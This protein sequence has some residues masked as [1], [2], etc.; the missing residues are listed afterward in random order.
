MTVSTSINSVV[1]RGNGA[2]TQ[3]AV[4]F[5]VLDVDHLRVKRRVFAT[6]ALDYT[7]IGTDYSYSGIDADSGTLT[8]SGLA[9]DDDYE[10]VIERIVPYTQDLDIV[11]AGGFYPETVE[12]QLD[13]IVMGVQQLADLAGRAVTVPVG[14]TVSELLNADERAGRFL[15]FDVNGDVI[16]ST[17]TGADAGLRTD[18]AA[19]TGATL[20]GLADG[21]TVQDGFDALAGD[22]STVASAADAYDGASPIA[23]LASDSTANLA[24]P[25]VVDVAQASGTADTAPAITTLADQKWRSRNNG[26]GALS[27]QNSATLGTFIVTKKLDVIGGQ[28]Y[29]CHL[30]NLPIGYYFYSAS[31][32]QNIV[33]FHNTDGSFQSNL[34]AGQYTVNDNAATPRDITF[35]VPAAAEKVSFNIRETAIHSNTNPVADS[36]VELL[37]NN[38]MLSS[39]STLVDYAPYDTDPYTADASRFDPDTSA[40]IRVVRQGE[41]CYFAMACQQHATKDVCHRFRAFH[42]LG[43]FRT[44][45][46]SGVIDPSGIRF[47]PKGATALV[48]AYNLSTDIH[49]AGTDEAPADSRNSV[50]LD[51]NHGP[52]VYRCPKVAH[53]MT[54]EDVGSIWTDGV[55][56]WVFWNVED[57]G[58]TTWQRRYTGDDQNWVILSSAPTGNTFTHVSGATHTADYTFTTPTQVLFVPSIREY[59]CRL[60]VDGVSITADGSASGSR[61]WIE[62]LFKGLNPAKVQDDIIANVGAAT[63]DYTPNLSQSRTYCRYEFNRYGAVTIYG[64]KFDV[65]E[66]TRTASVDYTPIMQIQRLSLTSDTPAGQYT[67]VELCIPDIG[68]AYGF[69]WKNKV[70]LAGVSGQVDFRASDCDDPDDPSS[71]FVLLGKIGA[72][73]SGGSAFGLDPRVGLGIPANRAAAVDYI[74]TVSAPKKSYVKMADYLFGDGVPDLSYEAVG[75][76]TPFLNTDPDL[77]VPGVIWDCEGQ[78]GCTILSHNVLNGKEV[79]VPS[80]FNGRFVTIMRGAGLQLDNPYVRDGKIVIST[81]S[82]FGFAELALGG[83]I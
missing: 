28:V 43:Y 73:Y 76:R 2:T 48:S 1:Y 42:G 41:Y 11:N 24:D 16:V 45:S 47:I 57:S 20:V 51:G 80:E 21:G 9:L 26:T 37:N 64:G 46:R 69:T 52:Y 66:Y 44:I 18:L 4:P 58:N 67:V 55:D 25:D 15:A 8:L 14:E 60:M 12:E 50:H 49:A 75:F 53:P 5:K 56:Q 61:V 29:R 71:L 13:L 63:P 72:N 77:T 83:A 33:Q 36:D 23:V 22:L 59:T 7:Y 6:G 82:G 81:P 19:T 39:G 32:S 79:A 31:S 17:G 70:D 78:A 34:T 62:E 27:A 10:L 40:P 3:F 68:A 54:N 35:T 65:E 38:I 74:F 30:H